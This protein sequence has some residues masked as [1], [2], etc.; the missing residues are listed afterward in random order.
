[1]SSRQEK[2]PTAPKRSGGQVL[3]SK[4][5]SAGAVAILVLDLEK[6]TS[7]RGIC[8]ALVNYTRT[9]YN[10]QAPGATDMSDGLIRGARTWEQPADSDIETPLR[11]RL[12]R[13]YEEVTS[14]FS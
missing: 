1:M 4:W 6:V 2:E 9:R 3:V 14:L 11:V 7:S 5:W 12:H 13:R 8:F 10:E